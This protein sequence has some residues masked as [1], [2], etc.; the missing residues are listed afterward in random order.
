VLSGGTRD[1][2]RAF[3]G[4]ALAAAPKAVTATTYPALLAAA[5]GSKAEAVD[6]RYPLARFPSAAVAWSTVVTDSSWACPTLAGNQAL[7]AYT[8]VYPYEF[9]DPNAPNVNGVHVPNF[10]LGA[11]HA[12]DLPSLFDLGGH[13]LLTTAAQRTLASQMVRYWTSFAHTGD[14]GFPRT[15]PTSTQ[16]QVLAPGGVPAGDVSAEHQC[17]FWH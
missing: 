8:A 3:V 5:F 14:P 16:V 2:E 11:A 6:A 17:A 12:S 13:N 1:E 7:A 15:I 9:A 10:P 4:G